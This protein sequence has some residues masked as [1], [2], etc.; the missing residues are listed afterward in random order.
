[1]AEFGTP[2][3]L[4]SC[5]GWVLGRAIPGSPYHDATGCYP[6]FVCR[7]WS[8]LPTDLD[9]LA[10]KFVTLSFVA[11]PFGNF[12]FDDLQRCFDVVVAFKEHFVVDLSR[13]PDEI[14]SSHHRHYARK[15]LQT[16]RVEVCP[17]PLRHLDEWVLLY[18]HLIARHGLKGIQAFSRQAFAKQLGLPGLVMFRAVQHGETV[19]LDLWFVHRDVAY[20]HL[21]ALSPQGYRAR[22]SYAL[23]SYLIRHFAGR[24]RWIDLGGGAGFRNN[25]DD[26]LT[27]FKRGWATGSRPTYFCGRVLDTPRY[28]ELTGAS[29]VPADGYFP[30]YRNG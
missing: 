28:L 16:I 15:A 9:S 6:L 27:Q 22:A 10:G 4:P 26:G 7:D 20:G 3:E 17:D 12:R 11:D 13:S 24:V 21:V 18:D 5:G 2:R 25:A 19:G 8:R 1:L 23:K 30:A 14:G 29:H